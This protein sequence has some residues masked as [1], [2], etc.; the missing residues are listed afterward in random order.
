M[1]AFRSEGVWPVLSTPLTADEESDEAGLRRVINYVIEGGVD[2]LW[3]FG[4]RGEGSNL[5]PTQHRRAL[6]ITMDEVAQRVPVVTGSG[7]PGTRHTIENIRLAEVAALIWCALPSPTGISSDCPDKPARSPTFHA[8][9][10]VIHIAPPVDSA[11]AFF[12]P[13]V[14]FFPHA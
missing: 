12:V 13:T 7:V 8:S 3:M 14:D 4:T 5:L 1:S 10:L 6:E 9:Y 11:V 2:G